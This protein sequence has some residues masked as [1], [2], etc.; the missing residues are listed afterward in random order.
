MNINFYQLTE[1][2]L[3]RRE[4]LSNAHPMTRCESNCS[5]LVKMQTESYDDSDD[6]R[7]QKIKIE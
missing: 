4:I 7:D 2:F 3:S 6:V 1:I 5:R